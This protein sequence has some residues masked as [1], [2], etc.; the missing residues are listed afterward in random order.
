MRGT[1]LWRGVYLFCGQLRDL[2]SG[3]CDNMMTSSDTALDQRCRMTQRLY[4]EW[5]SY[6]DKKKYCKTIYNHVNTFK[7]M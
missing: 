5:V 1:I 6:A 7:A 2:E 3:V 4:T